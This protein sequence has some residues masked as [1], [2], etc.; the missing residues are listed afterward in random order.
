MRQL[1]TACGRSSSFIRCKSGCSHTPGWKPGKRRTPGQAIKGSVFAA[2]TCPRPHHQADRCKVSAIEHGAASAALPRGCPSSMNG[3]G[4]DRVR[5]LSAHGANPSKR[6]YLRVS[7]QARNWILE[8]SP[9]SCCF[10]RFGCSETGLRYLAQLPRSPIPQ[11][12]SFA[13]ARQTWTRAV[14]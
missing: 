3:I 8:Y 1:T 11:P 14:C 10:L 9:V 5:A 6:S 12:C 4:A 7:R 13:G 2:R